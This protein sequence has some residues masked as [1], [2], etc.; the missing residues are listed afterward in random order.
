MN[1]GTRNEIKT[2]KPAESEHE[3]A[4]IVQERIIL[5]GGKNEKQRKTRTQND[6]IG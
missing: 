4:K 1:G 5:N 2:P 6:A 3:H